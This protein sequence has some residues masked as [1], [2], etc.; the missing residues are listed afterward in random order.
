[1]TDVN[2]SLLTH[3]LSEFPSHWMV[4]QSPSRLL[5]PVTPTSTAV[6]IYVYVDDVFPRLNQRCVRTVGT[7]LVSHD[8][9]E[10]PGWPAG[11]LPS[12]T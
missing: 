2:K 4:G 8:G 9:H 1:M 6:G 12:E 10:T 5:G 11:G 7:S 3:G